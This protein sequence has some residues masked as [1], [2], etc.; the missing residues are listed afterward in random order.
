MKFGDKLQSLRKASGLSQ[1]Q[2][3]DKLNVSRQAVSKWESNAAYPEM[4]KLVTMCKI[5]NC[6]FDDLINEDATDKTIM[7]NK[8]KRVNEYI[9]SLL[10][11]IV[12]SINM[13]CSMKFTSLLRCVLEL[14]II[15]C[16]MILVLA[17]VRVLAEILFSMI[18]SFVRNVEIGW[19]LSDIFTTLIFLVALAIE[20]IAFIQIYKIR[21]LDYYDKLVY[22]YEQK[23]ETK[24]A[25]EPIKEE[26]KDNKKVKFKKKEKMS[27]ENDKQERI[28]IRDVEHRPLAFL[29][30]IA[31]MIMWFIKFIVLALASCFVISFVI[32]VIGLVLSLCL[33]SANT[34]FIGISL[35]V[36]AVIIVN[37]EILETVYCFV[38]DKKYQAKR[39]FILFIVALV[40]L[41]MGTGLTLF[42][43]KDFKFVE[44]SMN[45]VNLK[46]EERTYKMSDDLAFIYEYEHIN[47]L[48][49]ET[50]KDITL[51][52]EYDENM[53]DADVYLKND[54]N[55]NIIT[56]P[57]SVD[58]FEIL[59]NVLNELKRNVIHS[60]NPYY[61]TK[62]TI[63]GSKKNLEKIAKN[64]SK[65]RNVIK[66]KDGE[67]F[68]LYVADPISLRDYC[69]LTDENIYKCYDVDS[70]PHCSY[71]I[72][73]GE[74]VP[75]TNCSCYY[76]FSYKYYY[77]T[78]D[79]KESE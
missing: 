48:I 26:T 20:V 23:C 68:Y 42:K 79:K 5:F 30:P 1:E 51:V 78:Q 65:I 35:A 3:A 71:E 14:I 56:N 62:V 64:I 55:Y 72:V 41:G 7:K 19:I 59:R 66:G 39:I 76:D 50:K 53:Y 28:I 16:M 75:S 34:L 6:S 67:N 61:E 25:E 77:C 70:G 33:I 8:S 44:T 17:G 27:L 18:F 60:Y 38:F 43:L 22:E 58:Y 31:K 54:N 36:L 47:F 9:N 10:E 2:L 32:F 24:E 49:N 11:F 21:Y 46:V 74:L 57:K 12:K 73:D 4:D 45:E 15:M 52:L 29:S 13:F 63:V 37:Y 40:M 69:V